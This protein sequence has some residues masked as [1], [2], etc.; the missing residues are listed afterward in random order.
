[1]IY[2]LRKPQAGRIWAD[3]PSFELR[4]G[5]R[6]SGYSGNEND[7][8]SHNTGKELRSERLSEIRERLDCDQRTHEG[9]VILSGSN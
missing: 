8:R 3:S 2:S 6:D 4:T 5:P 1:M 7:P 9:E